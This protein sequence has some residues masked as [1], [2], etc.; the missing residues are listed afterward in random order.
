MIDLAARAR[1]WIANDTDSDTVSELTALLNDEPALRER[2]SG[3]LEFGTAG[4]RGIIGAGESRMNAAVVI[5][6]TDALCRVLEDK[7]I[8]AQDK[9]IVIGNDG[10]TKS[11]AFARAAA[12]IAAARGFKVWLFDDYAPTP[13]T[14]YAVIASGAAAGIMVTASHNPPEYNGYKVYWGNGAQIISPVDAWVRDAAV[15]SVTRGAKALLADA[16]KSGKKWQSAPQMWRDM[17]RSE[18]QRLRAYP[19]LRLNDMAIAYTPMHGVGAATAIRL[20]EDEGIHVYA[21]R[22]QEQPDAAFPTVKFPNPEEP[23]A[24]DLVNALALRE[25]CDLSVANDPDADRLA[26]AVREGSAMRML[27]G[28]QIGTML[29]AYLLTAHQQRPALVAT[30]VVSSRALHALAAHHQAIYFETLTGFKWIANGAISRA[31]QGEFLFGYEEALGFTVGTLVRDKDGISAA[32]VFCEMVAWL[33]ASGRTVADYEREIAG[34]IGVFASQQKS[35]TLKG[36]D[37]L[38]RMKQV[39]ATLRAQPPQQVGN[40]KVATLRDYAKGGDLPPTDM[41]KLD[42]DRAQV[43]VR[44][45]GTEPKLKLYAEASEAFRIG[46]DYDAAMA[47]ANARCAALAGSLAQTLAL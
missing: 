22:E 6:T 38:E 4:L 43:I 1:A 21:V 34:D 10:R 47:R 7:V 30:S 31:A 20:I 27:S 26:I 2:F 46:E 23:G 41:V 39:M 25:N 29:G 24:M 8:G 19:N 14:A 36:A 16:E 9:G 32:L 17:Y 12:Q 18:V 45:S 3:P 13:L 15:R 33:K 35:F 37:G 28:N 5:T 44:P 40:D 42:F 11:T